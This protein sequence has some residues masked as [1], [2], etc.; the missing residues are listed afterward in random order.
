MEKHRYAE[1]DD[2]ETYILIDPRDGTRREMTGAEISDMEDME[3]ELAGYAEDG[4]M[5]DANDIAE[6]LGN[7]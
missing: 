5:M 4:E 3:R 1:L 7:Q 2:N 6:E